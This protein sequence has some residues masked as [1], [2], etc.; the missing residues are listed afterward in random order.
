[1]SSETS[2]SDGFQVSHFFV[3]L[4]LLA[5]T[6]AVQSAVD[7]V[8]ALPYGKPYFLTLA[9]YGFYWFTLHEPGLDQ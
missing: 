6:V 9:P 1:M 8:F 2:T 7:G 5:A 4:S 3:L